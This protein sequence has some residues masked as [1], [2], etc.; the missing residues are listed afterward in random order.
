MCVYGNEYKLEY[1]A[2]FVTN[3]NDDDMEIQ[4]VKLNWG[5]AEQL[6]LKAER[7][8]TSPEPP[9][10]L[11]LDPNFFTCKYCEFQLVCHKQARIEVNCRACKFAMATFNGEFYC[12]KF[13]GVIPRDVVKTGCPQY[14]AIV[15]AA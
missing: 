10:K 11:A 15:N 6:K 12:N 14:A 2:Y 5:L 8:V 4:I 3:K 13:N 7:I 1:A 9:P